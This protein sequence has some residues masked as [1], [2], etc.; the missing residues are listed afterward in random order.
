[1]AELSSLSATIVPQSPM[2]DPL[3]VPSPSTPLPHS[4]ASNVLSP[5][6]SDVSS[7]PTYSS[8]PLGV[9]TSTALA[10]NS[11][12]AIAAALS[13]LQ[14]LQQIGGQSSTPSVLPSTP[15]APASQ[16]S[17]SS[18]VIPSP[19]TVTLP[20]STVTA[21]PISVPSKTPVAPISPFLKTQIPL[22]AAGGSTQG[23]SPGA[24]VV[25]V[26]PLPGNASVADI[27]ASLQQNV[28]TLLKQQQQQGS[29]ATGTT[30]S[31]TSLFNSL[32][33]QSSPLNQQQKLLLRE[34]A[35]A[36]SPGKFLTHNPPT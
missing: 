29:I 6:L 5:L 32:Q 14:Q 25:T 12:N 19:N 17:S 21:R 28:S 33:P 24:K 34:H 10:G 35:S 27:I 20:G 3:P 13:T 4:V 36:A 1:M 26:Q 31:F 7:G 2:H 23:R 16:P 18:F 30:T 8:S 11:P 22:S 9:G 15:N